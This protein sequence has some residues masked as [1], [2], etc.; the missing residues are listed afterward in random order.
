MKNDPLAQGQR[1]LDRN[2]GLAQ[3]AH[4]LFVAYGHLQR[5]N[6]INSQLALGIALPDERE[7]GKAI[8]ACAALQKSAT[9]SDLKE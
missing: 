7:L 9:S 2:S 4:H 1:D 8:D 5:A 6:T 3:I